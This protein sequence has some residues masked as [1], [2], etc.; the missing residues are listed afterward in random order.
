MYPSFW[1]QAWKAAQEVSL[2]VRRRR[3]LDYVEF[4]NRMAA[5]FERWSRQ[6]RNR[7]R[8]HRVMSWLGRHGVLQR[9]MAVLDIGAGTGAFTVAFL[10][11]GARVT[12]LEPAPA[13]LGLLREKVRGQGR[14]EVGFLEQ[15]WEKV[16]PA[17]EGLA[18]QYD[19]VFASLTPGVRDVAT[20]E[21]MMA[22]S[23]RWCFLCDFAG[24]RST[25]G[26]EDLWRLIFHEEMPVPGHDIIYPLNYLYASGYR[27]SF[28]TGEEDWSEE[29]PA[30]E[31]IAGLED[32][33]RVYTEITPEVSQTIRQYVAERSAGGVYRE[34]YRVRLGMILWEV[35]GS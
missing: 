26:R 4:W 14:A 30:E 3:D 25:P 2:A 9:G 34:E 7:R 1:A 15:A 19:L 6:D 32:F 12:A 31:A 17:A 29:I 18:G 20:L 13:M 10:R 21:K 8:V 24:W 22:C 16:D 27:L 23:R 28:Q 11:R 33:F 35:G 5:R